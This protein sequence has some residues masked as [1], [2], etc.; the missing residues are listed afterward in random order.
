VR[1]S[2]SL[3]TVPRAGAADHVCRVHGGDDDAA[4]YAVAA[5]TFPE[6]P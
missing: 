3:D 4:F 2:G 6:R 5:V 1:L